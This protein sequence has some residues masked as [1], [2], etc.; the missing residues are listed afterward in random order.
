LFGRS[1][2]VDEFV[3]D[4]I[5]R[6]EAPVRVGGK[7]YVLLEANGDAAFRWRN[8][9]A[10]A[11]KMS[12]GKVV[13]V[14]DIADTEALLVSMCLYETDEKGMWRQMPDGSPDPKY[15]VPVQVIRSWPYRCIKP[16]FDWVRENSA[17]EEKATREALMEQ[18][19]KID[20]LLEALRNGEDPLKNSSP[21]PAA[22]SG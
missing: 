6:K 4:D 12:S 8:A 2:A 16:L 1:T 20:D 9:C 5:T 22:G 13:G 15:Q 7:Q 3:F 21:E 10:K 17:L 19:D 14:G 18:R 11:A